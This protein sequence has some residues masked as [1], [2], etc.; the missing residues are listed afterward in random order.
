MLTF[1]LPK[2][3][4]FCRTEGYV[5]QRS[6]YVA[7]RSTFLFW[8]KWR[9]SKVTTFQGR[10][11]PLSY[12]KRVF[13][14]NRAFSKKNLAQRSTYAA[15][16]SAL[17]VFFLKK[18]FGT[19]N[20][21]KNSYV[22][23]RSPPTLQLLLLLLLPAPAPA[24]ATPTHSRLQGLRGVCVVA[25]R[26]SF[27]TP[28]HAQKAKLGGGW[29]PF[30]NRGL[31]HSKLLKNDQREQFGAMSWPIWDPDNEKKTCANRHGLVPLW[32]NFMPTRKVPKT[33]QK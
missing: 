5:A 30:K 27:L 1:E 8:K 26:T 28:K 12:V 11:R 17:L 24:P 31:G 10:W 33:L 15:Q 23:Q 13:L 20:S 2:F 14:Q 18:S 4:Y 19:I 16:R 29:K 32:A 25:K 7:Q 9:S 3:A 6:T 21:R 22:A